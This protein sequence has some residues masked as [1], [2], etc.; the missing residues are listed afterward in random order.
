MVDIVKRTVD[1]ARQDAAAERRQERQGKERDA[2]RT[3]QPKGGK[4]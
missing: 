1:R 3:E 2:A 4:R